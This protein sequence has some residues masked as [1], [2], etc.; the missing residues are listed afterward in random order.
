MLQKGA[1]HGNA[2]IIRRGTRVSASGAAMAVKTWKLFLA[3][4]LTHATMSDLDPRARSSSR[5]VTAFIGPTLCATPR[6]AR[7]APG[8][9]AITRCGPTPAP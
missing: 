2:A 8:G 3:R 9:S 5:P 6:L 7:A 4:A 1:S